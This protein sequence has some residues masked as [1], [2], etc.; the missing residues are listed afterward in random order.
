MPPHLKIRAELTE[1]DDLA[2]KVT[3]RV[4]W[5][6][7]ELTTYADDITAALPPDRRDPI[8]AALKPILHDLAEQALRNANRT[9]VE[10]AAAMLKLD[11]AHTT[12]LHFGAAVTPRGR[13]R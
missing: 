3:A 13:H 8:I 6:E 4:E 12:Q 1:D 10:H 11:Q 9:A 7:G 5:K 2:V